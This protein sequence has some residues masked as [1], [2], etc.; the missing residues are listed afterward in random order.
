M[1]SRLLLISSNRLVLPEPLSL[2]SSPLKCSLSLSL[3]NQTGAFYKILSCF[4]LRDINL[5]KFEGRPF[6]SPL[7]PNYTVK[8]SKHNRFRCSGSRA[9][10]TIFFLDFEKPHDQ[11]VTKRLLENITEYA[12]NVRD[13]GTYVANVQQPTEVYD[14]LNANSN[15][16]R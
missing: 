3:R 4:A 5:Y 8:S 1:S 7:E 6:A 11:N 12:F 15:L 16:Y 10:T 13:L 2:L 14:S 9:Y